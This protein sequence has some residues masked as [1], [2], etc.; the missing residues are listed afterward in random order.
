MSLIG[1]TA[2]LLGVL[3]LIGLAY[4]LYRLGPERRDEV[5]RRM[6]SEAKAHRDQASFNS[7]RAR[8][9]GRLA[10]QERREAE[11]EAA[12]ADEHAERAAEHAERAAELEDAIERAGRYATFHIG[13]AT[14]REERLA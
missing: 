6:R 5:R 13:R 3:I 9:L 11:R 1:L 12:L 14:E 10:L 8:T 2:V 4:T 7:A